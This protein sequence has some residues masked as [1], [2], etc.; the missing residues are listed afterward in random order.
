[1][2]TIWFGLRRDRCNNLGILKPI[3]LINVVLL[4]LTSKLMNRIFQLLQLLLTLILHISVGNSLQ[5]IADV[6]KVWNSLTL[7]E[8]ISNFYGSSSLLLYGS[9]HLLF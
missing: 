4:L 6:L 9:M 1:M 5:V 2:K 7:L 8:I 3:S